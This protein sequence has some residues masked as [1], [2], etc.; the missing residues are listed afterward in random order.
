[1][2]AAAWDLAPAPL[3]PSRPALHLVPTGLP[4]R[5]RPSRTVQPLRITRFG[6]LLA[7]VTAAVV[8]VVLATAMLGWRSAGALAV[9][10]AV[11]VAPAQTLSDIAATELPGLSVTEA[12]AQIQLANRMSTSQVHAGQQLLIPVAG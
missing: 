3:A 11:T 12:V 10:H 8:V 1:M 9:D 5:T 7:T 4:A 6:R 2:S